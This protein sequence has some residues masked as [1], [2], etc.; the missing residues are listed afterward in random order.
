MSNKKY[1]FPLSDIPESLVRNISRILQNFSTPLI[2]VYENNAQLIGSGTFISVENLDGILTANHVS[3]VLSKQSDLGI[4]LQIEQEEKFTIPFNQLKIIAVGKGEEE[5]EGPDLS[6]IILPKPKVSTI[7]AYKTFYNLKKDRQKILSE[8]LPLDSAPWFICG[9]PEE[10]IA[11]EETEHFGHGSIMAI[12]SFCGLT[13]A[14]MEISR[15]KFDYIDVGAVYTEPNKPPQSFRGFSGGG[16]WQVSLIGK[17]IK[18]LKPAD[19]LLSGVI[20][21]QSA[22]KDNFRF[23]RCHGKKSIYDVLY[24][25][26]ILEQNLS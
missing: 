4:M 8:P 15:G 24:N 3:D 19:Y 2:K 12:H 26:V 10:K 22:L 23:V 13:G 7:K 6:M 5:S 17:E 16:L 1:E 20:Y 21:Y 18:D 25:T 9:N 11:E 14:D